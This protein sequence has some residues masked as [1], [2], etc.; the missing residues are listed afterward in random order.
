MGSDIGTTRPDRRPPPRRQEEAR[1]RWG[2][3]GS[4][5]PATAG[6]DAGGR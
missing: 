1:G 6:V 5:D 4:G 3:A 2:G